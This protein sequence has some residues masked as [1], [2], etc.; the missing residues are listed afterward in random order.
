MIKADKNICD[1]C[2]TCISVCKTNSI[3]LLENE[4]VINDST[5]SS[6]ARCVKICPFG[7]LSIS[8]E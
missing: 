1:L 3:L 8:N 4:L 7:A 2:G 6:C 5:C